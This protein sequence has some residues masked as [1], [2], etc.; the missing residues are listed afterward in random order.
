MPL[1]L[2]VDVDGERELDLALSRL[3]GTVSDLSKYWPKVAEAFYEIEKDQFATEGARTGRKWA[4]LSRAY[5]ARKRLAQ[6]G[7]AS[8][9]QILRLTDALRRSLTAKGESQ[10][11]Y[12]E[13]KDSLT[14]GTTVPYALAHQ[15]G[16]PSRNLPARPEIELI[17]KDA[18][19]LRAAFADGIQKDV[20]KYWK[21]PTGFVDYQ[22][23]V[24]EGFYDDPLA[25]RAF[26][27]ADQEL[28]EL[29]F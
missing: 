16:A 12:E 11:V 26:E 4:P 22:S 19:T 5:A 13:T 1:T 15:R 20:R 3:S 24:P 8:G 9:D 28:I 2:S 23:P 6:G 25:D 18:K 17:G 27:I 14:L 21:N 10:G 7:F 29:G